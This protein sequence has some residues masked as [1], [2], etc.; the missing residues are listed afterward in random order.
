MLTH[1]KISLQEITELRRFGNDLIEKTI[2]INYTAIEGKIKELKPLRDITEQEK[3]IED[4]YKKVLDEIIKE[5]F[6]RIQ[7]KLNPQVISIFLFSKDGYL[8]RYSTEGKDAQ[9]RPIENT[10]L[11]SER[12]EVG[13]SFSGK[14]AQGTPYGDPNFSNNLNN[15]IDKLTY[16]EDYRNKLGFLKCGISAPLDSTHRTFGTLEVINRLDPKSGRANKNL[17]F[18]EEE[19]CWLTVL[20]GHLARAIYRI[21]KKQEE[22][23]LTKITCLLVDP[24]DSQPSSDQVYK[25]ITQLF[26][27]QLSP[28]KACILRSVEGDRLLVKETASTEDV[29]MAKKSKSPRKRGEG[30]VGKVWETGQYIIK[31]VDENPEEFMSRVWM[32]EQPLTSFICFPLSIQGEV[33]GTLSLFT[34]YKH[35]FNLNEID[36]LTNVSYLLAAYMVGI[37]KAMPNKKPPHPFPTTPREYI[38]EQANLFREKIAEFLS[39]PEYLGKYVIF[40]N[41]EVIDKDYNKLELLKRAYE[42]TGPRPVFIEKVSQEELEQETWDILPLCD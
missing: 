40:E 32:K 21:R 30:M 16:G 3:Y 13:Q 1:Q 14:A 27:N 9:N 23:I 6:Q 19:V 20:G 12:Y 36:F 10:W 7:K 5:T 29:D 18:S 28:Y 15:I 24:S 42:K 4:T 22:R 41:G 8:N 25:T 34:G 33:V 17:E 11:K 37:K 39:N 26:I 2:A 31:D 35:Q 38:E